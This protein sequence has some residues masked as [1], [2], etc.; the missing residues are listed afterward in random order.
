MFPPP[1]ELPSACYSAFLHPLSLLMTSRAFIS[2]LFN[3]ATQTQDGERIFLVKASNYLKNPQLQQSDVTRQWWIP[4]SFYKGERSTSG[5]R[6]SLAS[7]KVISGR[8]ACFP[9]IQNCFIGCRVFDTS[10]LILICT[11]RSFPFRLMVSGNLK[12]LKCKHWTSNNPFSLEGSQ[13]IWDGAHIFTSATLVLIS[14]CE[15]IQLFKIV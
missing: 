3:H 6:G 11:I 14:A 10:K 9:T 1:Q 4:S 7:C 13:V 8:F 2:A 5:L 15:N 12:E